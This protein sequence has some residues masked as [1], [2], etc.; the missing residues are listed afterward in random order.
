MTNPYTHL[1]P[2]QF[3]RK[4]VANVDM[5]AFDPVVEPRFTIGAAQKVSTAGSCFAQHIS[6]RLSGIGFNYFVPEAG[7]HL[8]AGERARL[9][10]GVFSARFGNLYTVRQLLQLFE[11]AMG[12]RTKMEVAWQRADGRYVDAFRPTVTPEGH[13]SRSAVADA[14]AEHLQHVKTMFVESDVF[15]FT[16]GLT[17]SWSN[18]AYGEVFPLAPGVAGGVYDDSAYRFTNLS[19]FDVAG[20]LRSF[21]VQLKE[22]NPRVNV[23]LTVSPVPLIAT[24]ENKN[25]LVATTYSKSVL[26]VAAEMAC[27][28]F[29]WVDY[30]PSYEIITGNFN[31]GR[32]YENDLREINSMGVSHAMRCFLEHYTTNAA[33]ATA[34]AASATA[35][36]TAGAT[37][38]VAAV[39]SVEA[40]ASSPGSP[41][42]AAPALGSVVCDEE[43]IERVSR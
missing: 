42:P 5:H 43:L 8:P 3:W 37:A 39:A 10:Y 34:T 16:L 25:A 15:V 1:P 27:N 2:H 4:A 29:D 19:V 35:A 38:M 41:Q 28:E 24:Y 13:D 17:E 30:F 11:E 21:L 23:L 40:E 22:V 33:A 12:R 32:Y 9:G 14:R 36:A 20:D 26:R 6:R 31:A 18:R 7:A